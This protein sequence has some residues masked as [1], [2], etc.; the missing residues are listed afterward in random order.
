VVAGLLALATGSSVV[1]VRGILLQRLDSEMNDEL[2]QEA[3]ELRKL[4]QG[5]DPETGKSFEGRVR[6]LF[7]LFLA[8]NVPARDEA[9]VT[10]V[11]GEPYLRSRA[12]TPYRL[13]RDP[14][15]VARWANLTDSDRGRVDTPEG[16]VEYIAV[17][18]KANGQLEGVFVAAIFRDFRADR[19]ITPAVAGAAGVGLA[20]LLIG[21]LLAWRV[22]TRILRP[23]RVV[24]D[25]A[26][27]ISE[28]DLRGRIKVTG[29]DEI[30]QL[31]ETFNDMLDRLEKAFAAQR[32]FIDDAGHELRTPITIIRG[33]LE[34]MA[35]DPKEREKSTEIVLDEL[36]RMSRFVNDLVLL[37][38]SERP[39][40]LDLTTV[41]VAPL[42]DELYAKATALAPRE[43]NIENVGR[44]LIVADRQ[45]LTQA[46]MQLAQNAVQHTSNRDLI[47]L[48]SSVSDGEARFWVR[49]KGPG[50]RGED[51]ARV[52]ER[53]R[54]GRG[55]RRSDGAGLGLSI[56]KAIAT[57]HFGRV[58]LQ[59]RPG[60]GSTF[61]VVIP[62]DQPLQAD[63][64][65]TT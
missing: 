58:E 34:V 16:P 22:A 24:K 13:D 65:V 9:H 43:W 47:A 38:R 23:V 52:F 63:P 36:E 48:G 55:P 57:A 5:S 6:R 27:S 44:G 53:F 37:A 32:T 28:T 49:D 14:E 33:H 50:I 51:Q 46:I 54:R 7:E 31:A 21:S 3:R 8:R 60:E 17:P 30:G 56:V 29:R 19:R 2:V 59:S 12:V 64:E 62:V 26:R 25:T 35:E 45:R 15:L 42:T 61:T 18:V 11:D 1:V 10:F 39:D 40:F 4:A 41:D 20:V